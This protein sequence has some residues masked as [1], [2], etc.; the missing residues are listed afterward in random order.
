MYQVEQERQAAFIAPMQILDDEQERRGQ[1][2]EEQEQGLKQPALL[3]F[4]VGRICR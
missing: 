3:L 2:S 4:R 1:T